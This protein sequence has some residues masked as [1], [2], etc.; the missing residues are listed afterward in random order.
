MS[1]KRI[2]LAAIVIGNCQL[3]FLPTLTRAQDL[4]FSQY[5]ETPSLVNPALTGAASNYRL[6]TVYKNQ[7]GSVT[8]PYVTYGAMFEMRL[9]LSAWEK[10]DQH[11]TEIYKKAL[12]KVAAGVDFYKDQ[13]GDGQMSSTRGDLSLSSLVQ[14]GKNATISAG[15]MGGM[16]QKTIDFTKLVWPDQY[17]G[18]GYDPRMN[19]GESI[20]TSNFTN[21]D[22]AFGLLWRYSTDEASIRANNQVQ[23]DAGAAMYHINRPRQKFLGYDIR[24]DR[25]YVFHSKCLFGIKNTNVS[26]VPS[27]M[28]EFQGK[29]KEVLMG[30]IIKYHFKDD[31]KFTGWIS[32]SY[33]NIGAYYRYRDAIVAYTGLEFKQFNLGISYDVNV[34]KLHVVSSYKGGV[35]ITLRVVGVTPY[36]FQNSSRF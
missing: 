25:K 26:L 11:L 16:V 31:S 33:F 12:R 7:W 9:K 18:A 6:G 27:I 29:T 3:L 4:H 24:L 8:V 35:E 5:N 20:S 21:G 28:A 36:I 1:R 32:G 14:I 2:L 10:V 17:N 13:A 19:S 22:F 23:A 15:L 34:S 30:S